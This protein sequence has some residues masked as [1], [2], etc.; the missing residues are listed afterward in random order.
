I[1]SHRFIYA[2]QLNHV[3][4][5]FNRQM[6]T[7]SVCI[8]DTDCR[9]KQAGK[10]H[11]KCETDARRYSAPRDI[12]LRKPI[13]DVE[14]CS[15]DPRQTLRVLLITPRQTSRVLL[16]IFYPDRLL[17]RSLKRALVVGDKFLDTLLRKLM[18]YVETIPRAG[19]IQFLIGNRL[20]VV[21]LAIEC[22]IS[23]S[24]LR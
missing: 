8:Q 6:A 5:R 20:Q 7:R 3:L 11:P 18:S 21:A 1:V 10:E 23:E 22:L 24:R 16:I 13:S 17:C 14:S 12:H 9:D 19:K 2:L 15:W 4:P